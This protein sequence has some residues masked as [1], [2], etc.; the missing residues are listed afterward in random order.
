MAKKVVIGNICSLMFLC[1]FSIIF[2]MFFIKMKKPCFLCFYLQINVSNIY[3]LM[4]S[5]VI[6]VCTKNYK[7]LSSILQVT[8]DNVG[9]AF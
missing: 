5:S 9:D 1:I 2:I 7:N 4:A 6:N 3:D 8:I